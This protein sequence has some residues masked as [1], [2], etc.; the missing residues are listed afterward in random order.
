MI[1]FDAAFGPHIARRARAQFN[2]D[3]DTVIARIDGV[4]LI[5]GVIFTGYTG[6]SIHMHAAGFT[7]NWLNN[8][9]VWAVFN[10]CFKQLPCKVAFVQ[11]P[12]SNTKSLEFTRKLGFIEQTRI[13]DVFDDG[14]LVILKMRAED[15]RWLKLR[16]RRLKEPGREQKERCTSRT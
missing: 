12:E 16:P 13:Y 3:C 10:Y 4:Q 11:V 5:G 1:V 6:Y 15:C 9:M 7:H 2:R 14:A 8:D